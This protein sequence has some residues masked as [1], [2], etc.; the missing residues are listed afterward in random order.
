MSAES[1]WRRSF[2]A[3]AVF[4]LLVGNVRGSPDLIVHEWGTFTCLQDESGKAIGGINSD[5]EPVP[6]FVH[7]FAPG[8]I[9]PPL[10]IASGASKS[11]PRCHPDVTMRLETPIVYFYPGKDFNARLNVTVNCQAGWLTQFYPDAKVFAIGVKGDWIGRL[12][13]YGFG[14][15]EWDNVSLGNSNE[16][17][18]TSWPVWTTPRHVN[19]ATVEVKGEHEKFLFYR[20]VANLAA[21]LRVVRSGPELTISKSARDNATQTA[22]DIRELWLLDVRTDGTAA[23]RPVRPF[24]QAPAFVAKTRA[25]F[26]AEEYT[27]EAKGELKKA[28]H[29]ALMKAGLFDDEA[30][31]LLDTWQISY[32]NSPGLRLFF[33]VPEKWTN[34]TLPLRV[35][36]AASERAEVNPVTTRVM[37]GRIEIVTPEQ[38]GLLAKLSD[39]FVTASLDDRGQTPETRQAAI[40]RLNQTYLQLGR[41]RNALVLDEL[42]RRP[43]PGLEAFIKRFGLQAYAPPPESFR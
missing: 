39:A 42:K 2:L 6:Q 3:L 17:P 28:L 14:R 32:F 29:E 1:R 31:A 36:G 4:N 7:N 12:Q 15:L 33:L 18:A 43:G 38:R 16:G 20:G 40:E 9:L 30:A 11:V 26:A 37:V 13:P 10:E 34:E 21:P 19:C 23:F 41:F 5:D 22:R 35:R 25:E 27:R 24:E 8:L